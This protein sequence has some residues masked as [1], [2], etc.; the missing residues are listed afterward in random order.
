M[1]VFCSRDVKVSYHIVRMSIHQRSSTCRTRSPEHANRLQ[2]QPF[3]EETSSCLQPVY[4]FYRDHRTSSHLRLHIHSPGLEGHTLR[5]VWHGQAASA[6]KHRSRRNS[7]CS[8]ASI[9]CFSINTWH[10]V[11]LVKKSLP[12]PSAGFWLDHCQL[13]RQQ[14]QRLRQPAH[15][16]TAF[17]ACKTNLCLK[18][19]QW[20][21]VFLI[22]LLNCYSHRYMLYK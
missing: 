4:P 10:L 18:R 8:V 21:I 17:C 20:L 22:D 7:S 6:Q 14:P 5:W 19:N 13:P 9:S 12:I 2:R 11:D 15:F 1:L 3:H 16:W